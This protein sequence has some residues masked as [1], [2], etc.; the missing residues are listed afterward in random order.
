MMAS[1]YQQ[2]WAY[3]QSLQAVCEE[4]RR[5]KIGRSYYALYHHAL[6]FHNALPEQGA[7]VAG[8]GGAHRQLASRLT[9]PAVPDPA[10]KARSRT[11]GTLLGL[12]R[13]LRDRADYHH[14]VTVTQHDVEK[15]VGFVTRGLSA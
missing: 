1:N 7:L 13:D 8:V 14:N 9:N 4:S 15:C 10:L 6:E 11:I 12:A 5:N 2:L 3:A